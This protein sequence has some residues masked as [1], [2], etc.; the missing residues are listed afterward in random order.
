MVM[1][2]HFYEFALQDENHK[3]TGEI[4]GYIYDI[5]RGRKSII[6]SNSRAEVERNIVNLKDLAAK[7][8]EP[9]V[10]MVHHGS[11]S[12]SDREYV[13]EQM[14]LSELPLVT[15]ATVTLEL[16]IDLGDLERIVQVGCPKSVAS[17]S[18]RL[19][20]SGRRNGVSEMC[21]L[22]DEEKQSESS[23]FYKLIN[24]S[25]VKCI[26]LIELYRENRIEPV[27]PEHYPFGIL[28]HQTMSFLYGRGEI[29]A[30]N[31]AQSMLSEAVFS[32]IDKEDYKEL[33][34]YMLKIGHIEKTENG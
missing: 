24:W 13:E 33:L 14:R 12:A 22:F 6:F 27:L 23:E 7:K 30:Y 1:A 28:Y 19:G 16:G 31:L 10:F 2:E 17:L 25:F 26:A 11:I 9:D 3:N 34:K 18:Q 20:R 8:G 29:K 15:G 4:F 32:H 21:F 5:T